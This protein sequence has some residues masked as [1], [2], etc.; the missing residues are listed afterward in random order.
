MPAAGPSF[1]SATSFRE[2]CFHTCRILR[3]KHTPRVPRELIG[4]IFGVESGTIYNPWREYGAQGNGTKHV[5]C[6][7]ALSSPEL[8][9]I[10][11]D[12]LHGLKNGGILL[13]LDNDRVI[14]CAITP[15][16]V[17]CVICPPFT[18]PKGNL[19]T[20]EEE[21]EGEDPNLE[22]SEMQMFDVCESGRKSGNGE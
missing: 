5:G 18:D 21:N 15:K 2:Q 3:E 16:T 1:T 8:D 14:R 4:Q 17:R 12:V 6:P 20:E 10:I 13:I 11:A 7:P 22:I 9:K 19:I